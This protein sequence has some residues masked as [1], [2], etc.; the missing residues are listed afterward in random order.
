MY[1]SGLSKRHPMIL[2]TT[3]RIAAPILIWISGA[4]MTPLVAAPVTLAEGEWVSKSYD[5]EG[6]WS[7]QESNGQRFL[8]FDEG[9]KTKRAPDLKIAFH[10][11]PIASVTAAN[12]LDGATVIAELKQYRGARVFRLPAGLDLSQFASVII[13]CEKFTVLWGGADVSLV[14][15]SQ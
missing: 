14:A 7:I 15:G 8:R 11:K 6:R 12:A 4:F 3:L 13:H 5:I 10:P 9:F 2:K 1:A